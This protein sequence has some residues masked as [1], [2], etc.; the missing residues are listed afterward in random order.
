MSRQSRNL[1]RINYNIDLASENTAKGK[2]PF[3]VME[4]D[5]ENQLTGGKKIV[6]L[7]DSLT[8]LEN[9]TSYNK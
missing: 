8:A 5:P 9:E 7:S 1:Q 6:V 3:G 2:Q 4:P